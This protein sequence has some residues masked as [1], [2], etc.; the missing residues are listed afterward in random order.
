MN[1]VNSVYLSASRPCKV[2]VVSLSILLEV[3]IAFLAVLS[4]VGPESVTTPAVVV[5]VD[6]D[7]VVVA[8]VP[9]VAFVVLVVVAAVLSGLHPALLVVLSYWLVSAQHVPLH[10][11]SAFDL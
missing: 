6:V 9:V 1:S 10:L 5:F 4:V 3:L 8:L 11:I 7:L 2:V